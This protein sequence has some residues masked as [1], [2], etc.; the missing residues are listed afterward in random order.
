MESFLAGI[1]QT[2]EQAKQA[3][4]SLT[5][6]GINGEIDALTELRHGFGAFRD[7]AIRAIDDV[8][9]QLIRMELMK[10][11]LSLFGGS[12]GATSIIP[13]QGGVMSITDLPGR[14]SGGPVVPGQTYLVGEKG[15]ELFSTDKSGMITPNHAL[16]GMGGNSFHFHFNGA[17]SDR[18]A[19]RTGMQA[20]AG[21]MSEQAR[22]RAKGIS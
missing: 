20:A 2:A 12:S 9:A 4:E 6:Q 18:E 1:P 8:I 17:M 15:P 21:F 19:R 7:A 14:A 5:V 3:M 11:A 10:L 16:A 13:L 22:A